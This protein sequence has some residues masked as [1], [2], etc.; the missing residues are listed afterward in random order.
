MSCRKQRALPWGHT[1][2]RGNRKR[3]KPCLGGTLQRKGLQLSAILH[4]EFWRDFHNRRCAGCGVYAGGYDRFTQAAS[5][6][7]SETSG[8]LL[9]LDKDLRERKRHYLNGPRSTRPEALALG[10][11]KLWV[12]GY[13]NAPST[14]DPNETEKP[15]FRNFLSATTR[16]EWLYMK[17]FL[18][19]G[20]R[21][22][23]KGVTHETK[24]LKNYRCG[25]L[26]GYRD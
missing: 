13:T 16:N 15:F 17:C 26:V 14:H 5:G 11:R 18:P 20:R 21:K 22:A 4:E 8:F 24:Y 12:G 3:R 7:M 25:N 23:N 2:P 6:S 19:G 9:E 1:S 10:D